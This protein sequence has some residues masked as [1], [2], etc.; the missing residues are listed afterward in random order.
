MPWPRSSCCTNGAS[1]VLI[2]EIRQCKHLSSMQSE[3]G[4]GPSW[5]T[6]HRALMLEPQ[7]RGSRESSLHKLPVT[8]LLPGRESV[9]ALFLLDKLRHPRK[10][11]TAHLWQL[12]TGITPPSSRFSCLVCELTIFKC[13][14]C[15]NCFLGLLSL[16]GIFVKQLIYQS[17]KIKNRNMLHGRF[18][19]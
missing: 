4:P 9:G 10:V 1:R 2:P 19:F 6:D 17:K 7:P 13:E 8:R 15:N 12:G 18:I 3:M 14:Y 16:K 11:R 5:L